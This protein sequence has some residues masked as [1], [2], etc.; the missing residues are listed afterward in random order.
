[1]EAPSNVKAMDN[2]LKA[3]K[4]QATEASLGMERDEA[5]QFFS[6]LAD[7]AYAQHE[8]MSIDDYCEMQNY[9]EE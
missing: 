2:K 9:E 4:Q 7:W 6:E 3:L 1:M 8:A 5:A